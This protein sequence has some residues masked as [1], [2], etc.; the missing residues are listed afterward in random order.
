MYSLWAMQENVAE[1]VCYVRHLPEKRSNFC[2]VIIF[3]S[4]TI[5]MGLNILLMFGCFNLMTER[6]CGGRSR[7]KTE[8]ALV[9]D[10]GFYVD[11]GHSGGHRPNFL[12]SGGGKSCFQLVCVNA[13]H[14]GWNIDVQSS[15]N[16]KI[17]RLI[18]C[19]GQYKT[20]FSISY[21]IEN[22]F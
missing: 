20:K 12:T 21:T 11:F 16:E 10:L 1:K 9:A 18:H 5:K 3:T 13:D 8:Q 19:I 22:M 15:P 2:R 7:L 14:S 4:K 17:S 6:V